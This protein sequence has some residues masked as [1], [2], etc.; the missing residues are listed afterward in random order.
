MRPRVW[1]RP[2]AVVSVA[3]LLCS[4]VTGCGKESGAGGDSAST[5]APKPVTHTVTMEGTA[6][7]PAELTIHPGDTVIW[8]NKD[9]FPHTATA[10]SGAFSSGSIAVDA[11][12]SYVAGRKGV[13]PYSCTFHPMMRGT[14]RVE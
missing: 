3:L 4:G 11:S 12:W 13:F 10:T 6:F 9:L 14:I 5:S 2:L 7:D 8:V 1:R